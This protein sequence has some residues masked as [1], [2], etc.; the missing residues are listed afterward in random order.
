ME[1]TNSTQTSLRRWHLVLSKRSS[2][3]VAKMQLER[4]GYSVYLPR[5]QAK[6]LRRGKWRERIVALFPRYLF[7]QLDSLVQSLGPIRS[8]IGVANIVRFGVE[9]AIVPNSIVN[10]LV[11]HEDPQTRLH[12]LR[13]G[14]WFKH[15]SAVRIA[16]GALSGLEG[17][18]QYEDGNDR[19]V[20]LLNLLGRETCVRVD[21][22]CVVP[23]A[24]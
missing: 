19:V 24:A 20:V 7:V 1:L 14:A 18:F 21:S 22:G 12:K 4:Q 8:T 5:L 13:I 6:V 15:G 23:S 2:E 17:I 9:Y 11:E 10:G 3:E 16:A